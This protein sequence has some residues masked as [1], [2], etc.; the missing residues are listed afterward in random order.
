[1]Y[2]QMAPTHLQ[3]SSHSDVSN[4]NSVISSDEAQELIKLEQKTTP[5]LEPS[6]TPLVEQD[7]LVDFGKNGKEVVEGNKELG[8]GKSWRGGEGGSRAKL[9]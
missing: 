5:L 3:P 2:D 6:H 4:E 1:M 7:Q 8:Q 9:Y